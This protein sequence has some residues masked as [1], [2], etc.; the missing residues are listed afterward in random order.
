MV[1]AGNLAWQCGS[2]SV[3]CVQDPH[4]LPEEGGEMVAT[5]SSR[6][7]A[8]LT[9]VPEEQSDPLP[10]RQDVVEA[11]VRNAARTDP[12]HHPYRHHSLLLFLF[13]LP[14][15][16]FFLLRFF[17]CSFCPPCYCC[18]CCC[19]YGCCCCCLFCSLVSQGPGYPHRFRQ[20]PHLP[21]CSRPPQHRH[22]PPPES[23]TGQLAVEST[24]RHPRSRPRIRAWTAGSRS[25]AHPTHCHMPHATNQYD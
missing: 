14:S 8:S 11:L 4:G 15:S 18:C 24:T 12:T 5:V 25:T 7:P 22:Q 9:L 2:V 16:F 23:T 17:S 21:R 19:C 13:L 20:P 10:G 6:S 1:C 3:G